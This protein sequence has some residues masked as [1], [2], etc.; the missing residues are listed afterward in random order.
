M[1]FLTYSDHR[2]IMSVLYKLT[3]SVYILCAR[4]SL[5]KFSCNR[6]TSDI[7][8]MS[9][10]N[11]KCMALNQNSRYKY[12]LMLRCINVCCP[13]TVCIHHTAWCHVLILQLI[14]LL[15]IIL[16]ILAKR[17]RLGAWFFHYANRFVCTSRHLPVQVVSKY[18]KK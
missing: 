8:F 4:T 7:T 18:R 3:K 1:F 5:S 12:Y 14:R 13:S 10:F 6:T 11:G 9:F 16:S 2:S 17:E 15:N